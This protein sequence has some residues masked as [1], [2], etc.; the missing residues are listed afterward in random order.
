MYPSGW[1]FTAPGGYRNAP[2]YERHRSYDW[3]G[4]SYY[5]PPN[6]RPPPS[7][8]VTDRG[9][10]TYSRQPAGLL[11]FQPNQSSL[12]YFCTEFGAYEVPRHQNRPDAPNYRFQCS[13]GFVRPNGFA[14]HPRTRH[15]AP[16]NI[17]Q[18]RRLEPPNRGRKY[19]QGGLKHKANSKE[20]I[21]DQAGQSSDAVDTDKSPLTASATAVPAAESKNRDD[22]PLSP[23]PASVPPLAAS[24]S[25]KCLREKMIGQLRSGTYQCLIC[26]SNVRQREPIWSCSTCYHAFHLSCIKSWAKKCKYGT[27]AETNNVPV[28]QSWRCPTCQTKQDDSEKALDCYC[29]C[30]KM[31]NPEYHPART[32]IPHGCD[33]VCGKLRK[34][35]PPQTEIEIDHRF[36]YT[37]THRCT[38]LCHPGPCPTCIANV[39]LSC[40]CG[41]IQRAALCGDDPPPPCGNICGKSLSESC[42][43]SALCAAGIHTCL[44]ACHLGQC[45]PCPWIIET[46][47]YCNRSHLKVKCGSTEA[48]KLTFSPDALKALEAAS[49]NFSSEEFHPTGYSGSATDSSSANPGDN[50]HLFSINLKKDNTSTPARLGAPP[51]LGTD[52]DLNDNTSVPNPEIEPPVVSIAPSFSCGLSCGRLLSCGNHDC[53]EPCHPGD[54]KPCA[55]DPSRCLTC[56]CG[57]VPLSKLVASGDVSGDRTKCTDPIATCPNTC[58]R[59]NPICGHSCPKLCHSGPCPPC[60]L[61]NTV[62]CRCGRTSREFICTQ[63]AELCKTNGVYEFLCE[64]ICKKKKSCG[65][66]KCKNKCCNLTIHSCSEICGRR[67]SCGKH[68]CE[69]LCHPGPCGTCWRGVIYT[70]ISCRCGYTVLQPPQP[71]GTGRPQCMSV[72]NRDHDCSHPVRHTCH[73]NPTCPPCTVL[74][75]KECPGGHGVQF[76]L[77]CFQPVLSCGKVCGKHLPFCSHTCQNMC[78]AGDCLD[79]PSNS[80]NEYPSP[81]CSQTC[82]KPRPGCGHPCGLPCHEV[83]NWT[84]LQAASALARRKSDKTADHTATNLPPC[85]FLVDVVCSCGRRK[86]KLPCHEVQLKKCLIAHAD[87]ASK[88]CDTLKLEELR[89]DNKS[90]NP[91]VV[92][93]CDDTCTLITRVTQSAN[94]R[95][96]DTT[97]WKRG[98]D[99]AGSAT[100]CPGDSS[101]KLPFEPPDYPKALRDFALANFAF[102]TNVERQ[103]YSLVMQLLKSSRQADGE[104]VRVVNYHFPPMNKKKRQFIAELAEFYGIE[105]ISF[106]PEPNRHVMVLA[107]R[108]CTRLP[109]GASDHRGSLTTLLQREFTGTFRVPEGIEM[110]TRSD[111]RRPFLPPSSLTRTS[112]AQILSGGSQQ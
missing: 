26:I 55:L 74:M 35:F 11:Y 54:C 73:D 103:L 81:L 32:S 83:K 49:A 6:N 92:L 65:R 87:D 101:E 24:F 18:D 22:S 36:A 44:S 97:S 78:H 88:Q 90:S 105:A 89:S 33:E 48:L 27:S 70:E 77:P 14:M 104:E 46:E 110:P 23:E 61:S 17:R 111:E 106:D 76:S 72:C 34:K 9:Y 25:D 38:E 56:P 93:A 37:C 51:A 45:P 53:P 102:A 64:R 95:F 47:C 39:T 20:V 59:P 67:L 31:R 66:H 62:T 112:Y 43:D 2:L 12:G 63:Y 96:A 57:R 99:E 94:S 3:N 7:Y 1:G 82:Q 19:K 108:G 107:K 5:I 4:P 13:G 16:T 15:H 40:P 109:G 42:V 85:E 52:A 29:F 60:K 75:T 8:S 91:L 98:L 80:G 100:V 84:C 71:C 10:Q 69:E 28:E 21:A 41:R 50:A 68:S 86:D 58:A 79:I 30:G